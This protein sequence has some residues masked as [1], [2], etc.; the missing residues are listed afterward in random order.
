[1]SGKILANFAKTV[2]ATTAP[3]ARSAAEMAARA[4][5]QLLDTL[6]SSV[7]HPPH[8][9]ARSGAG[10]ERLLRHLES[11]RA[12]SA[13]ANTQGTHHQPAHTTDPVR[14][15]G[16]GP[17]SSQ[18]AAPDPGARATKLEAHDA[19]ALNLRA[20]AQ[21][22]LEKIGGDIKNHPL[23]K[24]YEA[25]V[26]GLKKQAQAMVQ[27][28]APDE[29]IAKA[30]W[31]QRRDIGV[32]FKDLTPGPLRD[33]IYDVNQSRYGDKLG[34]SFESLVESGRKKG[35]DPFKKIIESSTRPNGDV[36]LLLA[37]FGTWL[38]KKD[39]AYLDTAKL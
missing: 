34:P 26:A 27:N 37:Q 6:A 32:K 30:M 39:A 5:P 21:E 31:Q 8:P 28:G 13:P 15:P 22:I 1:M 14:A 12:D 11:N 17:P 2:V 10:N 20:K 25:E 29:A 36:N 35:I 7:R 19:C 16:Q 4:G 23:R 33:Y 24:A 18:R 9:I 38:N 3:L